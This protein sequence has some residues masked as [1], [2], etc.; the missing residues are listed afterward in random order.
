MRS[1]EL[2]RKDLLQLSRDWKSAAF[3]I[4]MPVVFTL[5]M[6]F[7][8]DS[9]NVEA[10]PRLPVGVVDQTGDSTVAQLLL[11]LLDASET[12]R[13]ELL[14][15]DAEEATQRVIDE[16]LAAA[17][18]IPSN[19]GSRVLAGDEPDLTVV[20][21]EASTTAGTIQQS[22]QTAV[23]RLY[24]AVQ[25]A[26]LTRQALEEAGQEV[27]QEWTEEAV[28][29]AVAAWEE[30]PF[31]VESTGSGAISTED[32]GESPS[33]FAHSSPGMIV[34]FTIAGL[35]GSAEILVAE[36]K[37]RVLQRLLTTALA[38]T[39][40]LLGHF[41][42]MFTVVLGQVI[43]LILFGQFALGL[44]YLSHPW[45]TALV[46]V[47]LA[48]WTS[49]LGLLIGVLSKTEDQAVI[50]SMVCMFLLAGLGGAWMPLEVTGETFQTI[51][52]L[53]PSAWAMDALKNVLIRDLGLQAALLPV[54]VMAAYGLAFFGIAAWR[55][56]EME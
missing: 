8:F 27:D 28:A 25:T 17:I 20:L 46:A 49:S 10:D 26:Q 12:I 43:L 9:G 51:G 39:G 32:E 52:H 33:G 18:V 55:F 37:G 44:Q 21:D 54:G 50:Y 41:I 22:L 38:R 48:F 3:L 14:D 36:R 45:A 24:G 7:I 11:D 6:G 5:M 30:P 4:I 35:I 2:A 42:A 31:Q 1:L 15:F 23:G 53:L 40:I 13:P 29:E 56:G 19:Y 16:E 47:T 34:Q